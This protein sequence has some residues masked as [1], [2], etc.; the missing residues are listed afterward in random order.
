MI[1]NGLW[2][3]LILIAINLGAII[4]FWPAMIISFVVQL[5]LVAFLYFFIIMAGIHCL[6]IKCWR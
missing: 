3:L 4:G 5:G 6:I 1:K 2:F